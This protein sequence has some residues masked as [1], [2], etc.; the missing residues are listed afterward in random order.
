MLKEV[1]EAGGY[2]VELAANGRLAL[3][4]MDTQAC[5][6]II[7]DLRVPR[8]MGSVFTV[9]SRRQPELLSRPLFVSGTADAPEYQLFLA[10]RTRGT[11]PRK[12][13]RARRSAPGH[14]AS[15]RYR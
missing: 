4:K 14:P 2:G 10:E 6:L 12:A 8:S 5:D 1:L 13:F 9:R 7:S 11:H 15:T 3:D